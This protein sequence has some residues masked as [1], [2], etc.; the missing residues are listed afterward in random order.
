MSGVQKCPETGGY[1]WSERRERAA[2]L[3]AEDELSDEVIAAQCGVSRS[4]LK[5]WKQHAEFA[6]RVA[7]HVEA[8]RAAI[9]SAGIADRVKRV[10]AL[11]DR[12]RR[13]EQVI[14]ARSAWAERDADNRRREMDDPG[15]DLE[16]FEEAPGMLTGLVVRVETPVKG[17]VK[18]EYKVD[19]SMLAEMRDTE[20][21][22]AQE[23]GQ[24]T[25]RRDVTSA[26]K[27]LGVGLFD[28]LSDDELDRRI[29]QA[30]AGATQKAIPS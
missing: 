16:E 18:V 4:A 20:R 11:N 29:A 7:G 13:L 15:A 28:D 19:T 10:K 6:A 27:A 1:Q 2:L 12:H 23:V 26:G 5:K 3:L 30:E 9:L 22:A 24:W 8:I 14:D 25:E 21:Q 17:G